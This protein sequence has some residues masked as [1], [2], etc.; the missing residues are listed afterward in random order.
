MR[1][2]PSRGR[3]APLAFLLLAALA[4]AAAGQQAEEPAADRSIGAA[5]T[6]WQVSCTPAPETET[7]ECS[8][9]KSLTIGEAGA[10]VAQA[11]V[12]AGTPPSLRL[13]AP[14]GMSLK[15]G[16][17][18]L[19]DGG[20]LATAPYVTSL[21]GG[22]IAVIDL[23]PALERARGA[24]RLLRI[25]GVQN[26]GSPLAFEMSLSGFAAGLGKLR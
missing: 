22:A 6:P 26:N 7:M 10:T 13:L 1:P 5:E 23:D 21:P 8:M 3:A 25:E 24:G 18:I 16:L 9:V 4:S 20:E 12:V 15:D 17:R 14:H 2:T 11:A 19:V